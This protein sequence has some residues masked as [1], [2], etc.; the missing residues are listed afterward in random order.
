MVMENGAKVKETMSTS[1]KAHIKT[2]RSMVMVIL[3]GLVETNIRE[4]M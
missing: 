1:T 3:Y 4:V 2:I